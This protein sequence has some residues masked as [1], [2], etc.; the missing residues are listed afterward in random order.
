M[1]LAYEGP[2]MQGMTYDHPDWGAAWRQADFDFF[3]GATCKKILAE[4]GIQ[5]ITWR[6]LG[7]LMK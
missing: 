2:E 4:E 3:A 5:L 6:E 7:K 1:H